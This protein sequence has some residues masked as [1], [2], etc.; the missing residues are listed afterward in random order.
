[1]IVKL[2]KTSQGNSNT[3]IH[4]HAHK[5]ILQSTLK[6]KMKEA[7]ELSQYLKTRE[8]EGTRR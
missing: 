3:H 1:M 7:Y 5:I 6:K 4:M 8:K 2:Q